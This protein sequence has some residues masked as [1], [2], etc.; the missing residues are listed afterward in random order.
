MT[1]E[2]FYRKWDPQ[3]EFSQS[4]SNPSGLLQS[5]CEVLSDWRAAGGCS[6]DCPHLKFLLYQIVYLVFR[7]EMDW[8]EWFD[9]AQRIHERLNIVLVRLEQE[10]VE[11]KDLKYT[12]ELTFSDQEGVSNE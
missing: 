12:E 4:A 10:G 1:K 5:A 3:I 9:E 11:R 7:R 2:E 6:G 8:P